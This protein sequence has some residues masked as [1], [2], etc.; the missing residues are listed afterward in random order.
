[1]S[2][3]CP[4]LIDCD[5]RPLLPAWRGVA[6]DGSLMQNIQER[7]WTSPIWNLL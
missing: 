4:R 2:A 7:D 3:P 1:M 5:P 6:F